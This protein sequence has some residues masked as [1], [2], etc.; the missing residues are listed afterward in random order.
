MPHGRLILG[1]LVPVLL[2]LFLWAGCP[3]GVG[4]SC[5]RAGYCCQGRNNT[6]YG[7]GTNLAGEGNS[8]S[9][10][11]CDEDCTRMSDCC[12]DYAEAC[13]AVDCEVSDWYNWKPCNNPCGLG[14]QERRREVTRPAQNG[15]RACPVLREKRA[16]IG[17]NDEECLQQSVEYQ[18]KELRE[19]ARILPA[20]YGA[21][22]SEKKYDPF[23]DHLRKNLYGR[24]FVDLRNEILA[25]T[26][27]FAKFEITDVK[28]GCNVTAF[29]WVQALR[30]GQ[31]VC[32]EC[33]PTIMKKELG[34]RCEGHGVWRQET[35][36]RAVHVHGCHGKWVMQTKHDEGTCDINGN[37]DF[38]L[39]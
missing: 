17:T 18:G 5:G 30:T 36:W 35:R 8:S 34:T 19:V 9:R 10:C 2:S 24:R 22:R 29:P 13:L 39:I 3:S 16:C 21:Y 33:Q 15:G 1:G 31:T 4:A 26:S 12:I 37:S 38:I 14:S 28:H 25:R 11:F 7:Y 6:C 32:V 20:K 27:Y 23:Q